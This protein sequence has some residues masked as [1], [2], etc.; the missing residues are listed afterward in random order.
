MGKLNDKSG[1]HQV[2]L[3]LELVQVWLSGQFINHS[4]HLCSLSFIFF[5][6]CHVSSH[7]SL[8]SLLSFALCFIIL[9]V[10]V[11]M[12]TSKTTLVGCEAH[13]FCT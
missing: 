8:L 6:D 2:S 13:V 7:I 3:K 5:A 10:I 11:L 4:I 9:P 12:V 1:L